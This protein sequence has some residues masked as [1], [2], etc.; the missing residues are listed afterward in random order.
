[1]A[2][3]RFYKK[4]SY[5]KN[6]KKYTKKVRRGRSKY[7]RVLQRK[8]MKAKMYYA[9]LIL[10]NAGASSYTSYVFRANDIYDPD[11]TGTGH[12]PYGW[13]AAMSQYDNFSVQSSTITVQQDPPATA[14]VVPGYLAILC[15]PTSATPSFSTTYQFLQDC[16]AMGSKV[17]AVGGYN[18]MTQK[19]TKPIV[20]SSYNHKKS[21]PGVPANDPSFWGSIIAPPPAVSSMYYHVI[22]YT[23]ANNDPGQA[24]FRVE[25]NYDTTFFNPLPLN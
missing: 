14:E 21:F 23:I 1:M 16:H 11:F 6:G 19:L 10:L 13:A 18:A 5:V 12:N 25:L 20:Y 7:S 3:K 8:T 15:L 24:A 9:D 4:R 2:R 17:Y 22:Y